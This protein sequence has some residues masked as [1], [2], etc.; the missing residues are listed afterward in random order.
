MLN[1]LYKYLS[2]S[3]F[4]L[5]PKFLENNHKCYEPFVSLKNL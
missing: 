2:V 3:S 4:A 1:V 5:H